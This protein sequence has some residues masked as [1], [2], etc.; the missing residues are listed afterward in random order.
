MTVDEVVKRVE[1]IRHCAGDDEVAH[2]MEDA[3]HG[4]VLQAI[5]DGHCDK[6]DECAKAALMTEKIAF[7]RWC[8]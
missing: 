2:S 1:E 4:D 8:A 7:E 3:L 6:P 5:A